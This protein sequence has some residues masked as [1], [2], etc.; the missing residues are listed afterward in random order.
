MNL[1]DNLTYYKTLFSSLGQ[2]LL[3]LQVFLFSLINTTG[4]TIHEF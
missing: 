3:Y 4:N 2:I 1:L